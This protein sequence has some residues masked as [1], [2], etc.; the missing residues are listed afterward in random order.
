MVIT[1][2][3]VKK[4]L[5]FYVA[6]WL[7]V[8]NYAFIY[9]EGLST[10]QLQVV[11]FLSIVP[12]FIASRGPSE[13]IRLEQGFIVFIFGLFC[14][15]FIG[16]LFN[17]EVEI[18][19][20]AINLIYIFIVIYSLVKSKYFDYALM[21]RIFSIVGFLGYAYIYWF[22]SSFD[23][24]NDFVVSPNYIGLVAVTIS[25]SALYL[26]HGY[27]RFLIYLSSFYITNMV[28]SRA[29]AVC[30][31]I[32]V[33][34][35]FL[36]V[37]KINIFIGK[38][39]ARRILF[40]FVMCVVF[41]AVIFDYLSNVLLLND[42]YRGVDSGMS[43]R[44]DRWDIAFEEIIANPLVG[45]GYGSS[46]DY[47]G[48]TVDNAYLTAFLELG[49]IGGLYYCAFLIFTTIKS[50][51]IDNFIRK[52]YFIFLVVFLVYGVFEKR[53]LSVGNSFSIMFIFTICYVYSLK[54]YI[55]RA[56]G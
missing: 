50:F 28:S 19:A 45:V 52:E 51:K 44:S 35:E 17:F 27:M 46:S 3:D 9:F 15:I 25:F 48:F 23:I 21:M 53:Y 39:F 30:V 55:G 36:F 33:I 11:V 54:N 1:E 22:A 5:S 4:I 31:L 14:F 47:L 8:F 16:F 41:G 32:I 20:R 12:F 10:V 49:W 6:L 26:K 13:S 37:S 34:H 56:R 18:F 7:Q 43:G 24:R 42:E 2:T 38:T 29:A 40:L